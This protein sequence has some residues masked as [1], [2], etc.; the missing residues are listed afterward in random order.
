MRWAEVSTMS[1]VVRPT[2]FFIHGRQDGQLERRWDP[3][4]ASLLGLCSCLCCLLVVVEASCA[5]SK[6]N[7]NGV[8]CKA[9][10][11]KTN[12]T[13]VTVHAQF[14]ALS[15]HI[16]LYAYPSGGQ[17]SAF[18]KTR[19]ITPPFYI[20]KAAHFN[21][22]LA[23]NVPPFLSKRGWWVSSSEALKCL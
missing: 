10:I 11:L 18:W 21:L 20:D 7:S 14:S 3:G 1:T 8:Q 4:D 5:T 6:L 13:C 15:R 9:L 19:N 2:A 17:V 22:Y 16:R 12:L 23:A